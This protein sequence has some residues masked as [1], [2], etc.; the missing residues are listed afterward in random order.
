MLILNI[1]IMKNYAKKMKN[2]NLNK[3]LLQNKSY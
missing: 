1:Q 3:I 2:L